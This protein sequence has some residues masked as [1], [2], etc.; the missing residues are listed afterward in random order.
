[1]IVLT[2][3]HG[4]S[5]GE[6][7]RLGHAYSLYPEIVRVPL[8]VHLP[9][10]MRG[11]WTSDVNRAV[12]TTDIAP[13][14]YR[15]LG[16][17]LVSPSPFFGEP[18]IVEAGRRFPA[19]RDRMVASSYGSVYGAIL[20]NGR[21]MYILDAMQLRESAFSMHVSEGPGQAIAANAELRDRAVTVIRDTVEALARLH[22]YTPK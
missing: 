8:I 5:L 20:D 2:S 3:D 18:L 12:F 17:D 15:L 16:Y 11:H 9:K 1:V 4:D 7:G 22:S 21:Q 10:S 13:T 14:L 19:P 6:D